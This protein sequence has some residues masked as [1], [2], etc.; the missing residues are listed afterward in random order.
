MDCNCE[1]CKQ[2]RAENLAA[3]RIECDE[4]HERLAKA[5][6][7]IYELTNKPEWMHIGQPVS[8]N[9]NHWRGVIVD[10]AISERG[11]IMVR[12][13]SPK[14][15]FY[16]TPPE[17]LEYAEGQIEP[18][19]ASALADEAARFSYRLRDKMQDTTGRF[20]QTALDAAQK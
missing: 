9:G 3:L 20:S 5:D 10:I 19:P 4:L 13:D 7:R 2:R 12:I 16:N 6:A 1:C 18:C 15:V 17:W 8:V 14:G 11:V